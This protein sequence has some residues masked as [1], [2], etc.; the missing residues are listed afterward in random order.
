MHNFKL[1]ILSSF[2]RTNIESTKASIFFCPCRGKKG[3]LLA[4]TTHPVQQIPNPMW[5]Q[6]AQYSLFHKFFNWG[7]KQRPTK[8]K[9]SPVGTTISPVNKVHW[10]PALWLA[11]H[12]NSVLPKPGWDYSILE[13]TSAYEYLMSVDRCWLS[14]AKH[15]DH[16]IQIL[17]HW[18][19]SVLRTETHFDLIKP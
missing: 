14:S 3:K 12:R 7:R 11:L 10:L 13:R 1:S 9:V 2:N 15:H 16:H 4:S 18:A 6:C 17:C 5:E 19:A 8:N